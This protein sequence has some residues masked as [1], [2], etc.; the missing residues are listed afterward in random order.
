MKSLQTLQN[1]IVRII[2]AVPNRTTTAPLLASLNLLSINEIYSYMVGNFV[3]KSVSGGAGNLFQWRTSNYRTRNFIERPL[4][5]PLVQ[6]EQSKKSITYAGP[7]IYNSI[8]VD[9]RQSVNYPLFKRR[10][11]SH[12]IVSN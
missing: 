2:A 5:L 9:I 12:L 6:S 8:P 4:N 11:K 1:K 3:Y 7:A 10:Y